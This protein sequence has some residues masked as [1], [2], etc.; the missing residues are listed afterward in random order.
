MSQVYIYHFR[1]G[2][3]YCSLIGECQ[4]CQSDGD[5]RH[6]EFSIAD[7][8]HSQGTVDI[9]KGRIRRHRAGSR[10]PFRFTMSHTS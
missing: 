6:C 3:G 7:D 2:M 4:D 9:K 1:E 8:R 5:I 10:W